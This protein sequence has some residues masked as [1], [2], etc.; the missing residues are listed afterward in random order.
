MSVILDSAEQSVHDMANE[1]IDAHHPELKG[2]PNVDGSRSRLCILMACNEDKESDE[3]PVKCHGYPAAAIVSIIPYKQRVD[4][5]ADAEIIIDAL[6]WDGLTEPQQRALLD[7]EITHL[8]V[9]K[10]EHGFVKTDD[11]GRPKLKLR[12]HDWQIGGFRSIAERYGDE[13]L[14]VR[15]ARDFQKEYG[16]VA[17]TKVKA[18]AGRQ[19]TLV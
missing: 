17:L 6:V 14:E 15:H 16:D 13:A 3:P 1:I 4:K 12:L 9:Q 2:V 18:P 7:H 11:A 8:E 19:G 10:D 5:R